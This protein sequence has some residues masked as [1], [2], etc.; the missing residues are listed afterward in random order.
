[1]ARSRRKT[2]I[3]PMT[4][5]ETDKP[6][7]RAEHQRERSTVRARLRAG[8]DDTSLPSPKTYGDPCKGD[9][10]GKTFLGRCQSIEQIAEFNA[11]IRTRSKSEAKRVQREMHKLLAK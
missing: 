9:K 6:F 8:A 7:K 11:E 4:G 5:G 2:P 1:M 3:L 10:D